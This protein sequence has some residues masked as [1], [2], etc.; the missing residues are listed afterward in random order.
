MVGPEKYGK[1]P[2]T[3]LA[4]NLQ[5]RNPAFA[6]YYGNDPESPQQYLTFWAKGPRWLPIAED[7][8]AQRMIRGVSGAPQLRP[9]D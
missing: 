6:P 1:A 2:V 7:S 9:K 5:N 4:L 3:L 8:D